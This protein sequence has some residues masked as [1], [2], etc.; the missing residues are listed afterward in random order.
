[1]R[2]TCSKVIALP[3]GAKT[4]NK[5]EVNQATTSS[6]VCSM[7]NSK[8]FPA[9]LGRLTPKLKDENEDVEDTRDIRVS[10]QCFNRHVLPEEYPDTAALIDS[11]S[12]CSV[13]KDKSSA[14]ECT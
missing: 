13:F 9:Q 12:T 3:P 8:K 14:K 7:H 6:V 1:M 5:V 4:N 11:G 10:F 2:I